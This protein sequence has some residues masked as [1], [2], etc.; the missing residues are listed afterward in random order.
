[1]VCLS[2]IIHINISFISDSLNQGHSASNSMIDKLI[3]R[4][5]EWSYRHF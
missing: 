3:K 1:M 5:T 2:T 4:Q